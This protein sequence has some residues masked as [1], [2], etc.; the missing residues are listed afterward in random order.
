MKILGAMLVIAGCAGTGIYMAAAWRREEKLLKELSG[1]FSFMQREME[2][3]V[4]PLP[5]LC[6]KC[7]GQASGKIRK[8]F[9]C[10]Q[11]ELESQIFPDVSRCMASALEKNPDLPDS[12]ACALKDAGNFLGKFDLTGQLAALAEAAVSCRNLSESMQQRRS[13]R[14]GSY[15]TLGLCAGAALAILFL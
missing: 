5:E 9:L 12:C 6:R 7:A 1:T 4:T 2:C 15:Q 11:E 8:I 13:E 10:L 3:R 14:A